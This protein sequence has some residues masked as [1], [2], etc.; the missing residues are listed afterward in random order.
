MAA[1]LN[2]AQLFTFR[3]VSQN[4][5]RTFTKRRRLFPVHTDVSF[6]TRSGTVWRRSAM[7]CYV[8]VC[9][10]PSG[11]RALVSKNNLFRCFVYDQLH[12]QHVPWMP[13]RHFPFHSPNCSGC[14]F[15]NQS[16]LS[17]GSPTG[18]RRASRCTACP[19][20]SLLS[21]CSGWV[22]MGFW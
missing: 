3:F 16:T 2:T 11:N 20:S 17:L 10:F 19:S 12:I 15:L 13:K 14:S 9:D 18:M 8:Y 1:K 7:F 21:L 4:I 5:R 22:N 6:W